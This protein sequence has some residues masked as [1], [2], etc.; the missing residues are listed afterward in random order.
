MK[1]MMLGSSK[2]VEKG[3]YVM[4]V[5]KITSTDPSIHFILLFW[6]TKTSTVLDYVSVYF[7]CTEKKR[8]KY[9]PVRP[10]TQTVV[11]FRPGE[12]GEIGNLKQRVKIQVTQ[13]EMI[14]RG[15]PLHYLNSSYVIN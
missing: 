15:G 11:L 13:V 5:L 6:V 12:R 4:N 3:N 10:R 7:H 1:P 2:I 9:H 14:R 8:Y